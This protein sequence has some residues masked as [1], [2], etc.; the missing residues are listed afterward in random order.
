MSLSHVSRDN[1][2]LRIPQRARQLDSDRRRQGRDLDPAPPRRRSLPRLD[3]AG[4]WFAR[5][6]R[7][8]VGSPDGSRSRRADVGLQRDA[9]R[10]CDARRVRQPG[11]AR[12]RDAR[13]R[14]RLPFGLP[15]VAGVLRRAER[16]RRDRGGDHR[17][18]GRRG[19]HA[20]R[21]AGERG[22]RHAVFR[23]CGI[24]A[25]RGHPQ[26][27]LSTAVSAHGRRPLRR[28][29][30]AAALAGK[31]PAPRARVRV[32]RRTAA[33]RNH[34]PTVRVLVARH[35]PRQP[36][37]AGRRRPRG[38]AN[39]HSRRLGDVSQSRHPRGRGGLAH[40]SRAG[41]AAEHR[42][43]PRGV[44]RRLAARLRV[45][46]RRQRGGPRRGDATARLRSRSGLGRGQRAGQLLPEHPDLRRL[47]PHGLLAARCAGGDR[48]PRHALAGRVVVSQLR[49]GVPG[50]R[51]ARAGDQRRRAALDGVHLAAGDLVDERRDEAVAV[52]PQLAGLVP[53]RDCRSRRSSPA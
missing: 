18:A 14:F 21:A 34:P 2:F 36:R 45:Q 50:P 6:R 30:A 9:D 17:R 28:R 20:D 25:G 24:H 37:R 39:L 29:S 38:S 48:S 23:R 8:G 49:Q 41:D 5:V 40:R 44:Q 4:R 22:A 35:G 31:A 10:R 16:G 46:A 12:R 1:V 43:L 47:L 11:A 51:H 7:H 15:R 53:Q 26:R 27:G 52:P 33:H 42:L 32:R 19:G 13:V 3:V